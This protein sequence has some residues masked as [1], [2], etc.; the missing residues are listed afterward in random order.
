MKNICTICRKEFWKDG[1]EPLPGDDR[2]CQ[3]CAISACETLDDLYGHTV[4][5]ETKDFTYPRWIWEKVHKMFANTTPQ[6]RGV[7][8]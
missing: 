8:E 6:P 3:A 7:A 4:V 5:G 1:C 2:Y